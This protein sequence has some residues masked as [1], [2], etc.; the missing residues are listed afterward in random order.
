MSERRDVTLAQALPPFV[1]VRRC[2]ALATL[3]LTSLLGWSALTEVEVVVMAPAAARAVGG[4]AELRAPDARRIA[5]V[6]VQEGQ[7]VARGAPI[8][9]LDDR[10]PRAQLEAARHAVREQ[11]RNLAALDQALRALGD[12]TPL[13]E[14]DAA[15]RLRVLAHRSRL[16]ELDADIRALVAEREAARGRAVAA[17]RLL[18]IARERYRSARTAA[19]QRALS[20]FELLAVQQDW[21]GQQAAAEAAAGTE[22]ALAQRLAAQRALRAA[23]AADLRQALLDRRSALDLERVELETRAAEAAERLRLADVRAP[24]AGVVDRLEVSEGDFV[25]R[26]E[27]LGVIVPDGAAIRFEARLLPSQVAFLRAGQPCR[28]KL[29]AL[30]FARYGALPCVLERLGRDVVRGESGAGHYLAEVRPLAQQFEAHARPVA[31]QPGA[32]AA[33][34]IVA[35][36]RTV[37]SFV[38]DPLTRFA[39]ETFRER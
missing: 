33:L 39:D 29:D 5:R 15:A 32:T 23:L 18:E 4:N 24:I 11:R 25:E 17:E 30:P 31:L 37:L 3:L 12:D 28:L 26:G 16:A 36:R 34:D 10:V 1:S 13:G 38:T 21:L 35:G 19:G 14:L 7:R 22:A 27:P 6:L 2:A 20:R 9:R 8:V